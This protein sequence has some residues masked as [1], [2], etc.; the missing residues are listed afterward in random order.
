MGSGGLNC[1]QQGVTGAAEAAFAWFGVLLLLAGAAL[2][3]LLLAICW[4][5]GVVIMKTTGQPWLCV[6]CD[7][8]RKGGAGDWSFQPRV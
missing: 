8:L 5:I 6:G 2:V 1:G 4:V 7:P 3:R